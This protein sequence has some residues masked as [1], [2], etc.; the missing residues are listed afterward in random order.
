MMSLSGALERDPTPAW[1]DE[2][3]VNACLSGDAEAWS[4]LVGKYKRLIFS[5]PI[6]LGLSRD[7][8]SEKYFSKFVWGCFQSWRT[9][10]IRKAFLPG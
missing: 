1:S 6:K 8:A 2:R 5:I 10:A 4:A 9:F 7:D 3:L